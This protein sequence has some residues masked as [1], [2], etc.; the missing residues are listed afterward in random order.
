[1]PSSTAQSELLFTENEQLRIKNSGL[2]VALR[3]EREKTAHVESENEHLREML[4]KFKKEAFGPKS[5]RWETEEQVVLEFNEAEALTGQAPEDEEEDE[6][7]IE[8]KGHAKKRGK[9]RPLP[10]HLPREVVVVELP[11]NERTASDGT[12]LKVIG[13]EISEKLE[14]EPAKMRVI[15]YHRLRYGRD[16]GDH[17]KTAPPVPSV[18][19]KGIATPSLLSAIVT[20]KY[21]DGLPLYRQE[22]ILARQG[23]ELSRTSMARWVVQAALVARPIWNILEER[24]LASP[25]LQ[26]DETWTQVLKEKGRKPESKSWMWVR[27][28]PVDTERIVLFD[29]DPHRSGAVAKRLLSEYRGILQC[30][31][32][33]SYNP[34]EKIPG[35]T[36]IGC[37][38]HGRR[39]FRTAA[40][41]SKKSKPLAS[42]ALKFYR[43][44]YDIEAEAKEKSWAE[45]HRLRQE[46]AAPIWKEFKAWAEA[47]FPKVLRKSSIGDALHYFLGEY[48][49]LVGYLRD[50]RCE[51]DN[52]FVER[53]IK[54]FAL[55]R[56]AWLFS[57]TP[58]GAEASALF[59]SFV[60]TAKSNG[61]NPYAALKTI[62][63]KLPLATTVD[64]F[65][66]LASILTSTP[67]LK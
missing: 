24:L 51:M 58:E 44:L 18:I 1:V 38:M 50:G 4:V 12:P 67:E 13:K 35:I 11:E 54:N 27:S 53:M 47:T 60:V 9:R 48:D 37:N 42:V 8:V 25:Y 41:G 36:R 19:P 31:G 52:G 34:L 17:V 30:D 2:E 63:E 23:V 55:G 15:Q 5:E 49:Y 29:Y 6:E 57:D 39:G 61:V 59:Y 56:N 40:D 10:E 26:C 20:A 32:Y 7:Q 22:E 46:K 66:R 33:Q 16:S 62:F 45:R 3:V 65:E 64:D 28:N 43:R 14:Y 21:A